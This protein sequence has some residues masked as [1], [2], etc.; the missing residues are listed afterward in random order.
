ML[1]K[2]HSLPFP[3]L[4]SLSKRWHV[5]NAFC[6]L[7]RQSRGLMA[8]A[9]CIFNWKYL[10]LLQLKYNIKTIDY[11]KVFGISCCLSL[12]VFSNLDAQVKND[13]FEPMPA[14][15]LSGDYGYLKTVNFYVGDAKTGLPIVGASVLLKG[16]TNGAI[17]DL[18][19]RARL[20]KVP[21]G[22][23]VEIS[24]V[25]YKSQTIKMTGSTTYIVSLR[26]DSEVLDEVVVL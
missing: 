4:F 18:D 10:S 2:T 17:T 22:Y 15:A 12:G 6:R 9:Y 11:E 3:F 20:K 21:D 26:E 1:T 23:E 13:S 8:E 19:G 14:I 7:E 24:Y 16:T 5:P 25:G